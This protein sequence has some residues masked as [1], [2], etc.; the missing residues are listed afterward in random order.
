MTERTKDCFFCGETT[1]EYAGNPGQWP[2]VFTHPD[3]TGIAYTHCTACVSTLVWDKHDNIR[4]RDE[5]IA[6]KGMW[7]EFVDSLPQH[8]RPAETAKGSDE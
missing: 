3:S 8:R 4:L 7:Y 6:S 1:S 5:F 2:L